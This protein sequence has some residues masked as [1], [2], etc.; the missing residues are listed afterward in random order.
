MAKYYNFDLP[1]G[2]T[3]CPSPERVAALAKLLPPHPYA[4]GPVI[5]DRESWDPWQDQP[6]GQHIL[7]DARENAA[8][9]APDYNDAAFLECIDTKD[10]TS[11]NRILCGIRHRQTFFILAEAIFNQ[12][13]F[14]GL[15]ESDA[16]M[17]GRLSTWMHPNN[18]LGLKNFKH[19]GYDND[20]ASCHSA[21]NFALI[22][23]ILGPR[24][25]D[26][27]RTFLFDEVQRRFFGPIR[28][29]IE[30]GSDL[31]WWLIAKH[32]WNSVNLSC[33]AHAA[34]AM[35]PTGEDRAWWLAAMESLVSNYI[36]GFADDGLCNEGVG[37]W[38]F[39]FIHFISLAE[40]MRIGSAHTIDML[41]TPKVRRIARFPDWA[42][43][44]PGM[45]PA[46]SDCHLDAKLGTWARIW[47]DNRKGSEPDELAQPAPTD[48]NPFAG[49]REQFSDEILL[50]MFQTKDPLKP[51]Y[52]P[53]AT[54]LRDW[55]EPSAFLICR[56]APTSPRSFAATF[57]GGNN[58][59]N[60]SHNDLGTF[61]VLLDGKAL[62]YDPGV[63]VY[64]MRTFSEQRYDSPLL[65]SYGHPV[66]RIGGQLQQPG[67]NHQ[68]VTLLTEFLDNRDRMVLDL[69]GGYDCPTL[70][71]LEREFV[72]D[73]HG[74]GSL[75]ITDT[76]EFSEPTE[77][78]SALITP[79]EI[80]ESST[81]LQLSDGNSVIVVD[82]SDST[83][84]LTVS[85]DIINQP[86]HPTRLAFSPQ[87]KVTSICV[88]FIIRPA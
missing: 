18:D 35:L 20:L 62:I 11:I 48:L 15:I 66:P 19:E 38:Y 39:G 65:N 80:S 47:L 33:C 85:R 37:Y 78:E 76:V 28:K 3:F 68:A 79:G 8:K 5:S 40:V 41:D 10:V 72:F 4:L 83:A 46:F 57:L 87:G 61:T 49:L 71:K 24:L 77:Y 53:P 50:W 21:L 51:W 32:N 31:D 42:E 75:T 88:R 73:R 45:F 52:R 64:S 36:D 63:E 59:V 86:P 58:G 55:F 22:H 74:D 44:Q 60:H 25:S 70:A 69:R 1:V 17:I 14:L 30:S 56:T 12:G 67:R 2:E 9:P 43:I 23:H 27:F 26:D 34:V 7:K 81:T 16:R 29:R 6:I 84:P 13:E 54:A 82:Y